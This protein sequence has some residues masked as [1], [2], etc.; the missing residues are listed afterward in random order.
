MLIL[1]PDVRL[2]P[3][4]LSRYVEIMSLSDRI[5]AL[6]PVQLNADLRTLDRNFRNGVL[7]PSGFDREH[8]DASAFPLLLDVSELFGACLMISRQA[9]LEVGGFDPLYFAY[10]EETDLSRR[11]VF[12]RFRL[13]VT[14]HAPVVHLR[15]REQTGEVRPFVAFLR[16][17]GTYLS[18]LKAPT[19]SFAL[20]VWSAV[21]D[22]GSAVLGHP[23]RS[24]PYTYCK[25]SRLQSFRVLWWLLVH[26][27]QIWLHR[28]RDRRGSQYLSKVRA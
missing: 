12:H 4:A 13:V 9:L 17:R 16:L 23:P 27:P 14:R 18:D 22:L 10:G 25:I 1:N 6:N 21:Q 26:L 7:K 5:G 11:I 2:P 19:K 24:Y 28:A 20:G 15:T 8:F 3:D